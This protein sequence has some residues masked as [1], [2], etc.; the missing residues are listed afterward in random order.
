MAIERRFYA[1]FAGFLAGRGFDVLTWDY[2]GI[3]G[4]RIAHAHDAEHM[5]EWGTQDLAGM[6]D[7]ARHEM[8][9]RSIAVVGHSCGGQILGLADNNAHVHA[10]LLV[11]AQG[12]YWKL[13]SGFGRARI[14]FYV[15]MLLPAIVALIGNA[16][17]A[18][19][20]TEVPGTVLS[21]WARWCRTE[22]YLLGK[23]GELRRPGFERLRAPMLSLS[24]SDDFYAP[25]DAVDWLARQ[26]SS[27]NVTRRHFTAAEVGAR[28]IDHFGFFRPEAEETLW[29]YAAAWL[30]AHTR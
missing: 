15:F 27:A 21:D 9:A 25:Q 18:F 1:P 30:S 29:R 8:K 10:A 12:G 11:A 13:W 4:S 7:Y 23:E 3:G 2:R 19:L 26:Y 17:R 5:V 14:A 6:I 22:N 28:R 20:G 24:F 16:P